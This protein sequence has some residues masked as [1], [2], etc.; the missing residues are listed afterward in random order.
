MVDD[1]VRHDAEIPRQLPDVAPI[2]E[3]R[4]DARVI[5]GIKA[6][7]RAV[8]GIVERQQ[9]NGAEHPGERSG[10]QGMQVG[11][12]AGAEAIHVG[13]ELNLVFHVRFALP[14][15]SIISIAID[16]YNADS[17]PVQSSAPLANRLVSCRRNCH[18]NESNETSTSQPERTAGNP[19][20]VAA[21]PHG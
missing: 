3:A 5:D 16:C 17:A 2:P 15:Q 6:G 18:F 20:R 4:I 13:D 12:A 8:D 7:V 19:P 21:A 10:Q 1:D 9:M 11:Q 14:G